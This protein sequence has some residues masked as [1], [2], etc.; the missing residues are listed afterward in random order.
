VNTD[1]QPEPSPYRVVPSGRVAGEAKALIQRAIAAGR[2]EEVLTALKQLHRIL[3]IYPQRG[4]PVRDLKTVAQTLYTL[5]FGPLF[6]EYAIDEAN[7][8]VFIGRPFKVMPH[9][10]FE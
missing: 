9:S 5:S 8:T 4:E 7:R 10:G 2:G 6:V 3:S 1:P